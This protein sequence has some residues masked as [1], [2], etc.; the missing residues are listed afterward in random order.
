MPSCDA[1][2]KYSASSLPVRSYLNEYLPRASDWVESSG[3][4][5]SGPTRCRTTHALG[6]GSILRTPGRTMRPDTCW[7]MD[8]A[9]GRAACIS[10]RTARLHVELPKI[11]RAQVL[12]VF[13]QLLGRHLLRGLRDGFRSILA[14]R[15]E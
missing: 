2:T 6:T 4:A 12:Q 11:F 8:G 1:E 3:P 5:R 13:L 7:G 9:D 10:S 14:L 15:E